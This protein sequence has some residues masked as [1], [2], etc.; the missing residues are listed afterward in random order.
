MDQWN[1]ALQA[2]KPQVP[3][4]PAVTGQ[5]THP[6]VYPPPSAHTD[7]VARMDHCGLPLAPVQRHP[8]H[9]VN[10]HH[11]CDGVYHPWLGGVSQAQGLRPGGHHRQRCE[12]PHPRH[13]GL[14]PQRR[15]DGRDEGWHHHSLARWESRRDSAAMHNGPR[16][17]PL[18]QGVLAP[19]QELPRP[20][21]AAAQPPCVN[22]VQQRHGGPG[23]SHWLGYRGRGIHGSDG[24]HEGALRPRTAVMVDRQRREVRMRT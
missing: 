1:H 3:E 13:R 18:V 22:P 19:W 20:L 24:G 21:A 14:H 4:G 11:A 23:P 16:R 17:A 10:H 9:V 8:N 7:G 12:G 5:D 2:K 6:G 15:Y